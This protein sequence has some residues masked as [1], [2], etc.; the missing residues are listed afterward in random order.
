MDLGKEIAIHIK[1]LANHPRRFCAMNLAPG[2]GS[3]QEV[4]VVTHFLI[5]RSIPY[6]KS[7]R[8]SDLSMSSPQHP[9]IPP[10][11]LQDHAKFVEILAFQLD[12]DLPRYSR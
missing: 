9:G 4:L 10:P 6:H 11:Q 5:S 3:L 1:V 12:R 8:A 7:D 2:I